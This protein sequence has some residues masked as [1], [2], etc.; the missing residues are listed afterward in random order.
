M[1]KIRLNKGLTAGTVIAAGALTMGVGGV[2]YAAT[3]GH[4]VLG[5]GNRATHVSTLNNPVGTPLSLK[6]AATAAPMRVSS[7][8]K[9]D[10]LN[11]DRLDG[12]DS[13][14]FQAK[15]AI[16][17]V[18]DPTFTP[19]EGPINR[20]ARA[21][22]LPS[23]HAVGGGG[24]VTA[25]TTDRLGEYYT[26]LVHSAPITG[27]GEPTGISGQPAAGWLVEA[28]NTAHGATGLS[29]R[30]ANLTAYVVCEKN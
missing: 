12:L 25:L 19:S 22:C 29:G 1:R 28:T 9:V 27:A 7:A 30:D 14:A 10:N 3:G 15:G 23:E 13:S 16:V 21:F 4:F 17:R 11:A 18:S 26:F 24:H 2:G 8:V 20:Q 6:G 5:Q